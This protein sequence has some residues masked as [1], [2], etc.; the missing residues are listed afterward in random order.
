MFKSEHKI[1][2]FCRKLYTGKNIL[3]CHLHFIAMSFFFL[4]SKFYAV[5]ANNKVGR[6][7][8]HSVPDMSKLKTNLQPVIQL[9]IH[10][11]VVSEP[12]LLYSQYL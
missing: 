12:L 4:L 7:L 5:T 11:N 1:I 2:M 8:R 6:F 3:I 9:I 10:L